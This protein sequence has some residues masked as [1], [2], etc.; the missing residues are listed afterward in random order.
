LT[1]TEVDFATV[2]ANPSVSAEP[3]G[4]L[5]DEGRRVVF[6][7]GD[8]DNP[9]GSLQSLTVL[10]TA[11]VLDNAGNIRG[12]SLGNQV[13][14]E[15]DAGSGSAAAA[16]VT[17]VEPT[18]SL[19]K[20][21]SPTVGLPGTVITFT[22]D[23]AHTGA[24]D[25]DAFDLELTDTLPA[26]LTYLTG[27]LVWTGVGSAPTLI[28]D[29]AAPVLE[30]GWSSFPLGST[31][32]IRY[33]ATLGSLPPGTS[34]SNDAL[35]EW[36]SLPGVVSTAQSIHNLLSTERDYDPGDPVNVYG[37]T[38]SAAVTVGASAGLP[39]T[40]FA[41]GHLTVLPLD[42]L[43]YHA[44]G[45]IWLEI[46]LLRKSV[47]VVGV[48]LTD[49]GWDLTWLSDQAGYLEGT[50]FPTWSGN[51]ALTAHAYTPDGLPGPFVHLADLRWGDQ[52]ILHAFGQE[53]V[54]EVR[55]VR[56]VRPSD[57]SVLRHEE[58]PWLTLLT[59]SVYDEASESY[60]R[61]VVVRAVLIEV[62]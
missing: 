13:T 36:T 47:S 32:Q 42:P 49:S 2:C 5:E 27:S 10:Y 54:Y 43:S 1:T 19:A 21:A 29:S 37:V 56:S 34:L 45:G 44:L 26:G 48:P 12:V 28:D 33:Q 14:W 46:P 30:V 9:T 18:L 23:I 57:L 41:P 52:V 25:A 61:R 35:L 55:Q 11:V 24:T 59:C 62:R 15:W 38:T 17:V 3:P 16:E 50:A 58:L 40:G 4:N 7:F 31:S 60:L 20:V 22:L 53:Y 6:D 51:S 8:V 39:A